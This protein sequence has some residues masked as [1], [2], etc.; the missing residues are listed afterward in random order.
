MDRVIPITLPD[1]GRLK[2]DPEGSEDVLGAFV[3]LPI[4]VPRAVTTWTGKDGRPLVMWCDDQ[5]IRPSDFATVLRG[6]EQFNRDL[7]GEDDAA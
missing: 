3:P 4:P 7:L 2:F 5:R 6:I 1:N